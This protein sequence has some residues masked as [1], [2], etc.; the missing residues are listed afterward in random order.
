MNT[1][2]TTFVPPWGP[3]VPP[4][5][6]PP[7][8]WPPNA[9]PAAL[10]AVTIAS[11]AMDN[12][13]TT[14][15]SLL[16]P[17]CPL[18]EYGNPLTRV[19]GDVVGDDVVGGPANA[20]AWLRHYD[21][22]LR[23]RGVKGGLAEFDELSRLPGGMSAALDLFFPSSHHLGVPQDRPIAVNEGNS[24]STKYK[25]DDGTN[26]VNEL[27]AEEC[28][29]LEVE[30]ED[31]RLKKAAKKRDKKARQ[32][33]RAKKETEIKVA[34]AAMKKRD[35]AITSWRSRVVTACL[36]GDVKKMD[37]L[38]GESPFKNYVYDPTQFISLVHDD[39]EDRGDNDD[40]DDRPKSQEEYLL[41]HM[42]WFLSNCLQKYPSRSSLKL[43][44]FANNLAREKLTKYILSVSF[45]AV[46]VQSPLT[47]SRNA[48]HFAAYKNDTSFIQWI[49]EYQNSNEAKDISM[50]EMLCEDGGWAPLHYATAGGAT[51]VVEL[52]L[53][54]GVFVLMR[55]DRSLTRFTRRAVNGITARELA[56]VLLS[57]AV[58]DDLTS[59]SDILDDV[60]DNRLDSDFSND[61]AE[62]MQILHSLVERFSDVENHGYSPPVQDD[63]ISDNS[64][65]FVEN[66]VDGSQT[67][68]TAASSSTQ[69]KV[70]KKKKKQQQ[71]AESSTTVTK[72]SSQAEMISAHTAP[73]GEDLS[74]PVAVALLGMGFTD[75]Q[76][77]S[78][79]HALGGLACATADD[80]VMWILSGGEIVNSGRAAEQ[81]NNASQNSTKKVA[82]KTE[83]TIAGKAQ[84]KAAARAKDSEEAARKRQEELAATKRA[85][86]K[87]EEQRRI[88]REW[89]ERE[90]ARQELEKNAK[91][92][93]ALERQK[94]AEMEKLLPKSAIL[95]TTLIAEMPSGVESP[96]TAVHIP[97]AAG[98]GSK[99]QH[100]MCH[101]PPGL[102]MTII[103]GGPKTGSKSKA[104]GS[105]MGI[106]QAPTLRAPK[107]LTRPSTIPPGLAGAT[108]SIHSQRAGSQPLFAPLPSSSPSTAPAST[109]PRST[110]TKTFNPST[111]NFPLI[112]HQRQNPP[113]TILQKPLSAGGPHQNRV[114]N[115]T[116]G[117]T[118]L[119]QNPSFGAGTT[120]APPGFFNGSILPEQSTPDLA[121]SSYAE[122]NSLGTIR[123]T[124]REFVPTSFKPTAASMSAQ[125][126][127]ASLDTV[128]SPPPSRSASNGHSDNLS[129]LVS[130]FGDDRKAL[131]AMLVGKGD[132]T[133]PSAASS[134]TGVSGLQIAGE[135]KA[136]Q[137]G[138]IMTFE[139]TASGAGALGGIQTSSILES[140]SYDAGQIS[141]IALGSGGIWGG[142]NNVN[143]PAS[144]GLAGLNFSSFLGSADSLSNSN[145]GNSAAGGSTW[146]TN[147][148]RGSIW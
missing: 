96:Q 73:D 60:V 43:Q 14:A 50:L 56:I 109:P 17:P 129:L 9:G 81:G 65:A 26:T 38:M 128:S 1:G 58:D 136:S 94:Q 5:P 2:T 6:P 57:G 143:Q 141:T 97:G 86:D 85:A 145:Q 11:F 102:P 35:K 4:I 21:A 116:A 82:H 90:Q 45:D 27:S 61:K 22:C 119:F 137:V 135:E 98:A 132:S 146:G 36:G 87:K 72:T 111:S 127:H 64:I 23:L 54:E 42:G 76:I 13:G 103:A 126:M 140:I 124:A 147:T 114:P 18:G 30:E 16:I 37:A 117:S 79:A 84:K 51:E 69:Q 99:H 74:D 113:T 100:S 106:P 8:G 29:A 105:N 130:S 47:H 91:I 83:V 49:I 78:A 19:G 33:E 125:S 131:P 138:S 120:V 44:P 63:Q 25:S 48:I 53:R 101:G 39:D 32:K 142:G 40:G 123:A 3:T 70:K 12:D 88:R 80:M 121:S 104:G 148:G 89:N 62:Y 55:T 134:I 144:L 95:P 10:A 52:L 139:S 34:E 20:G 68:C 75:D 41:M 118:P 108:G 133:A 28:M 115:T 107:I 77:K 24:N 66:V 46:L 67:S 15:S 7:G 92:V 110:H 93:A 31:Q 122:I 71:H 112:I 59:K